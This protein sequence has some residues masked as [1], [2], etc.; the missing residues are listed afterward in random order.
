MIKKEFISPSQIF[1]AFNIMEKLAEIKYFMTF[2][3][4]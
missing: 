1:A 2:L 4:K 3:R